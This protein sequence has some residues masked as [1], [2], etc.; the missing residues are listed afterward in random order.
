[1]KKQYVLNE[2]EYLL[3]CNSLEQLDIEMGSLHNKL[4]I[5][6]NEELKSQLYRMSK[7]IKKLMY[8]FEW[9]D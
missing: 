8:D 9:I 2:D 6:G 3:V 5:D 1:M 7:S 4:F